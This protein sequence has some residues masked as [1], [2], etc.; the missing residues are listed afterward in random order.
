MNPQFRRTHVLIITALILLSACS[1]PRTPTP[2]PT[3]EPIQLASLSGFLA[4][5]QDHAPMPGMRLMPCR[6]AAPFAG[7]PASCDL[8]PSSA[9]TNTEGRFRIEDI[10][11]GDYV[12]LIPSSFSDSN[13]AF[14][15]LA[16]HTIRLGDWQWI[17]SELI[18]V[19]ESR[20]V[21]L[22]IPDSI[23][24]SNPSIQPA[25]VALNT[26]MFLDSPFVLASTIDVEGTVI[27]STVHLVP[28]LG[29]QTTVIATRPAKPDLPTIRSRI[30]ALTREET[31]R[32]DPALVTR[33]NT[34]YA[35]DD[36][37]YSDGDVAVIDAMRSGSLYAIGD[38]YFTRVDT[39]N[40]DLLKRI[41][42]LVFDYQSG[43]PTVVGSL[44]PAT[45]DVTET[46]TGYVLNV[47]D[48]PGEWLADGPAGEKFYH[49][50]WSYYI[51][52]RRILPDPFIKEAEAFRTIGADNVRRYATTY[53]DAAEY[54]DQGDLT[55]VPWDDSTVQAVADWTPSLDS[56]PYLTIP[57]SGTIDVR[58]ERFQQAI[59]SNEV[60]VDRASVQ[61]FLLSDTFLNGYWYS[62]DVGVQT[63]VDDL[64]APYRSGT[65]YSDF[66]AAIILA[67]TYGGDGP[68]VIRISDGI[69]YG[70]Q[71]PRT[72]KE[73]NFA[74]GEVADVALGYYGTVVSRWPHEMDHVLDFADPRNTYP[75]H[76]SG[77][78][79]CEPFKY[80]MEYMW[81]VERYPYDQS[82]DWQAVGSG[83]TLARLLTGTYP[84]SG[85]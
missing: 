18:P 20:G 33:W 39:Y 44:D 37:A 61:R 29:N 59:D 63:V 25:K 4:D 60:A 74:G 82:D 36:S 38:A 3:P 68:L 30:G 12:F 85:C 50:G 40:A 16:G 43:A 45:R 2:T 62:P 57:D 31:R 1:A 84:N 70:A 76:P 78:S 46:A 21:N 7:F 15:R 51:R 67:A 49:Y 42:Y 23:L 54:Y 26:L 13:A 6:L 66:E 52:W 22:A 55:L 24:A 11:T 5:S 81:W 83:L 48:N 65:L 58:R 14:S 73:L 9:F 80:L 77:G 17:A 8:Q 64:L 41:G 71:V 27:P 56:P 10:P 72:R 69:A 28:G 79:R 47:R 32:L 35:G 34:F 75:V 53:Q 19:D